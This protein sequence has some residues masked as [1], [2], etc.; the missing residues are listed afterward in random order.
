MEDLRA[1]ESGTNRT[2]LLLNLV[3][4]LAEDVRGL[5]KDLYEDDKIYSTLEVTEIDR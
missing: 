4:G 5:S 3:N 2:E 1:E